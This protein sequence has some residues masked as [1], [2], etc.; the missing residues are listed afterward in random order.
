MERVDT[1][2]RL[3]KKKSI[4]LP[5]QPKKSRK[6]LKI[7]IIISAI[8]VVFVVVFLLIAKFKYNFFENDDIYV[9]G[10]IK[11]D[12][13]SVEY[14]TETKVMKSNMSYTNGE[15]QE[16]E[17]TIKTDFLVMIT[18]RE[19]LT[20][21]DYVNNASLI[22]LDSKIEMEGKEAPLSSLNVFNDEVMKEFEEKSENNNYTV[23]KFSFYKNGTIKD[24][25]FP[26]NS[27][28][29]TIQTMTD[30]INNV[31][32]KLSRS[33]SEDEKN[34]IEIIKNKNENKTNFNSF[35]E[36][37]LQRG[38]VDK[39]SKREIKGSKISKKIERDIE[40]EK[41]TEVRADTNLF[42]ETQKEEN[43]TNFTNF[44]LGIKDLYFNSSSK[45]TAYEK[46]NTGD[47]DLIKK[48]VSRQSY[49]NGEE[50]MKLILD[51]E[52]E[53][54]EKEINK[55]TEDTS[56]IV[57]TERV[58]NL[59]H[60]YSINGSFAFNWTIVEF[61]VLGVAIKGIYSINLS[62]GKVKNQ[63]I[64]ESGSNSISFGNKNGK[65]SNGKEKLN[66]GP[67]LM[68]FIPLI[69]GVSI[70]FQ[71]GGDISYDVNFK[72][73][74]YTLY[75]DGSINAK[76]GLEVGV[77]GLARMGAGVRGNLLSV[78]FRT[79]IEQINSSYYSKKLIRLMVNAGRV[80]LYAEAYVLWWKVLDTRCVIWNGWSKTWYW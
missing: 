50:L 11:R 29:D 40:D 33:K 48:V 71:L 45:I 42:L 74:I 51:K 31:I 60:L 19:Y 10:Q 47:K 56:E 46:N 72:N 32:P 26:I 30:L 39:Y 73:Q 4:E 55:L 59:R 52:K 63:L 37:E 12:I 1:E 67:C 79:E 49:S 36:N 16:S 27:E 9:V 15:F 20:E 43:S 38:F 68:A 77:G 70:S 2:G 7:S 41:L 69:P 54:P 13:N 22:I 17:Q 8:L 65:S 61:N 5:E 58:N 57:E 66:S 24:I 75:F 6:C 18:D 76:A 3:E 64:F 35:T 14:F 23:A 62:Q 25:N 80:E 21:S 28:K 53:E 44:D 34:G 78:H